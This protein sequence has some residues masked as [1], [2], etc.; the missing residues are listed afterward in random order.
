MIHWSHFLVV[1]LVLLPLGLLAV[2][3]AVRSSQCT[4][5]YDAALQAERDRE[6]AEAVTHSRK[7]RCA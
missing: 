6:R 4:K 1:G 7:R 5:I 3:A 2:V